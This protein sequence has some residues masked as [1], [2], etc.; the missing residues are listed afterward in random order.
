MPKYNIF[1][2]FINDDIREKHDEE[3]AQVRAILDA[4]NLVSEAMHEKGMS[5]NELAKHIDVSKG[6]VSR[7]LSGSENVS[8]KNI[9]RILHLLG[10]D[11]VLEVNSISS[12]KSNVV[13]ADF[14]KPRISI[15]IEE[16]VFETGVTEWNKESL[17][18]AK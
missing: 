16:T 9:A 10:K 13:W 1:E 11:L 4:S 8:L 12:E 18:V 14:N 7:L 2:D 5:Q 3:M 15:H 17:G 6:Y